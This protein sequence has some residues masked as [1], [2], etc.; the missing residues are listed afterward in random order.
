MLPTSQM[1]Y[2][3]RLSYTARAEEAIPDGLYVVRLVLV[4][5]RLVLVGL[6]GLVVLEVP[7]DHLA[8]IQ[9]Q[10]ILVLVHCYRHSHMLMH[11][12]AHTQVDTRTWA[13][14]NL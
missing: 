7:V 10:E 13:W 6:V 14:T 1:L 11:S 4:V 12:H 5:V 3:A 2:A 9:I 8:G